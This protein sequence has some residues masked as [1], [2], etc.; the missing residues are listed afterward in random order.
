MKSRTDGSTAG[1]QNTGW[2]VAGSPG[3]AAK[4]Q[5]P[6]AFVFLREGFRL[7]FAKNQVTIQKLIVLVPAKAFPGKPFNGQLIEE[8]VAAAV[9]PARCVRLHPLNSS[10]NA[11]KS[12]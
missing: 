9:S 5:P 11:R 2:T 6:T 4:S 1:D 8:V 7:H 10:L 3:L 12:S